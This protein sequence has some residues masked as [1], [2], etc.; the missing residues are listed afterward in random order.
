MP[1]PALEAVLHAQPIILYMALTF[2]F[3]FSFASADRVYTPVGGKAPSVLLG[4]PPCSPWEPRG[5]V[6][7]WWCAVRACARRP[8]ALGPSAGCRA[9]RVLCCAVPRGSGGVCV[10]ASVRLPEAR[11]AWLGCGS[12]GSLSLSLPQVFCDPVPWCSTSLNLLP[13]DLKCTRFV[14]PDAGTPCAL[15]CG[16]SRAARRAALGVTFLFSP[17]G[18]SG[19]VGS[20]R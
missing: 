11:V 6:P 10:G 12:L 15:P 16:P 20:V 1:C 18:A 2:G 17:T 13:W 19:L 5:A 4:A 3:P 7:A 9:R 14:C 8:V